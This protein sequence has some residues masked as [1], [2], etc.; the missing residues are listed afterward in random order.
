MASEQ[1]RKARYELMLRLHQEVRYEFGVT[2][3]LTGRDAAAELYR[4]GLRSTRRRV[5]EMAV[6]LAALSDEAT[7]W[8]ESVIRYR[9]GG[10][11]PGEVNSH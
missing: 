9:H 4:L 6:T 8:A 7:P 5:Q 3:P 1:L 2:V 11:H 10:F